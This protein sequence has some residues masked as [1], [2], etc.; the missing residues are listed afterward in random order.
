[1]ALQPESL[2]ESKS[3]TFAVSETRLRE[4]GIQSRTIAA[5]PEEL[6]E[7]VSDFRSYPIW[8]GN[9]RDVEVLESGPDGQP[10]CVKY[11][12]GALGF[13]AEYTLEYEFDPPLEMRWILREGRIRGPLVKADIRHLDGY[14]RFN[15]IDSE[16]TK[17]TYKVSAELSIPLGPLRKKAE[18]VIVSSALKELQGYVES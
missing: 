14:Y 8:T 15:S 1:M 16:S 6:F 12:S 5:S 4:E 18:H 13:T 2:A 11:T 17:V 10:T 3:T 7:A 9:V